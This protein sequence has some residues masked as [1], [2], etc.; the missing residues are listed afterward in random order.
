MGQDKF[1]HLSPGER[2]L[3][4]DAH[5]SVLGRVP[6]N[7]VEEWASACAL[8][9]KNMGQALKSNSGEDYYFALGGDG[10]EFKA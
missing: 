7:D 1:K 5:K 6:C 8:E 3:L 10:W 2:Q 9:A 4:T